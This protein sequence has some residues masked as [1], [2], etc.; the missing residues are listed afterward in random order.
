MKQYTVH[1]KNK[2]SVVYHA[3]SY[4]EN[5]E[6][7]FFHKKEDKSDFGSFAIVSEVTGIDEDEGAEPVGAY[8]A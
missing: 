7:Y 8:L 5:G 1:F 6:K 3:Y 2:K 4:T